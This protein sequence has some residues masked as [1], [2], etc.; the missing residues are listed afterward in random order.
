MLVSSQYNRPTVSLSVQPR[1]YETFRKD[2]TCL[3]KCFVYLFM[4][5]SGKFSFICENRVVHL[6]ELPNSIIPFR[7]NHDN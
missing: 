2:Y 7:I 4:F 1:S 3:L 5:F 6:K